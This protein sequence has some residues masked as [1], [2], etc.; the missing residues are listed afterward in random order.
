MKRDRPVVNIDSK[1]KALG[2]HIAKLRSQ[3]LVIEENSV[4]GITQEQLSTIVEKLSV[5]T[6]GDAERAKVN[7]GINSL[8][9]IAAAFNIEIHELLDINFSFQAYYY[10]NEIT[11]VKKNNS[12]KILCSRREY[13]F[14]LKHLKEFKEM[15]SN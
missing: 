9:R 14:F 3:V 4:M 11:V 10:K 7:T 5:K 12:E 6:V 2:I 8:Y 13:N 15:N 1:R